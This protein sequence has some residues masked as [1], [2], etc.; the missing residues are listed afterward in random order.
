MIARKTFAEFLNWYGLVGPGLVMCKDGSFLAAWELTGADFESSSTQEMGVQA[1][2]LVHAMH[3]FGDGDGIWVDL[4]RRPTRG[5][6]ASP[7]DYDNPALRL[8]DAERKARFESLGGHF[9]NTLTLTYQHKPR[10]NSGGMDVLCREVEG[11]MREVESRLSVV[12]GMRRLKNVTREISDFGETAEQDELVGRL[13]SAVSG[14]FRNVTV[15]DIPV[16][17]DTVLRPEFSHPKFK[18]LPQISGRPAAIIGVDGLRST[19]T[20]GA[21]SVL[22]RMP[23]EY[24]WTTRFLPMKRETAHAH[25][26][27]RRRGWQMK[28]RGLG[29]QVASKGG[30]A[31]VNMNAVEM[32]AECET[33]LGEVDEGTLRYGAFTS[34]ISMFGIDGE[35]DEDS[36]R[37]QA[38]I[39][40]EALQE[41]GFDARIETVN[42]AEAFIGSLPGHQ[43]QNVRRPTV[44]SLNFA[45]LIPMNSVWSGYPVSPHPRLPKGTPALLRARTSTG[46]PYFF[47]LHSEDVGHA[48]IFG[49]TGGG[50]SVLLSMLV[51]GF[52]RLKDA[53]IFVFD[54]GYSMLG[55]CRVAGGTHVELGSDEQSLAPLSG[56]REMG[57]ESGIEWM[58]LFAERHGID[59]TPALRREIGSAIQIM[60]DSGRGDLASFGNLI[61]N[62][63]LRDALASYLSGPE[64]GKFDGE[65][66]S[67]ELADLTVFETAALG[68]GVTPVRGLTLDHVFRR[69]NHRLTGRPTLIL[70]D[71]AWAFLKDPLFADRIEE[72]LRT[73]RRQNAALVM[74][75]Q[76]LADAGSSSIVDVLRTNVPTKIYLPNDRA[77]NADQKTGYQAVGLTERQIEIIANL[78]AKRDYYVSKPEGQRIVDFFL[79]EMAL[80]LMGAT[81]EAAVKAMNDAW[82]ADPL[83]FWIPY[84]KSVAAGLDE[85]KL[86]RKP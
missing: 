25:I 57:V 3:I 7:K 42:A 67:F 68:T 56:M 19:L 1:Q 72:W 24:Q 79:G 80:A 70:V 65:S 18:R 83:N 32:I 45:H 31:P 22:E 61:Q 48:L 26:G 30:D 28:R 36:V 82:R 20:V 9:A 50:K 62:D 81:D 12:Y 17:L 54:K 66:D 23:F 69:I 35:D 14:R 60:H 64:T 55:F 11:R 33:A 74:A 46:E 10:A 38:R 44:H 27:S 86:R 47:N 63:D 71:E 34:T 41:T 8:I 85:A 73:L 77:L 4:A 49:P 78:V 37:D 76:G 59:L 52:M 15:P 39:V 51:L 58:T 53:Q 40:V 84:A 43:K 13:A 5:Y 75:T 21:L 6:H 29:S 16:Y 2:K